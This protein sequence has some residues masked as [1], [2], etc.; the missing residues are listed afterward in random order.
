MGKLSTFQVPGLDLWFYSN[1]H[2]PPHFHAEKSGHW[3]VRVNFLEGTTSVVYGSPRPNELKVLRKLATAN[4]AA[5]LA[6]WEQK[7]SR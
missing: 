2:A 4:R 1:D 5:L 6:E 7:V 3:Q